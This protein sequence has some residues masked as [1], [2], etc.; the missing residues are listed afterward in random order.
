MSDIK[1]NAKGTEKPMQHFQITYQPA[2]ER[3]AFFE[4]RLQIRGLG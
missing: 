1:T 3:T 2:A 4:E